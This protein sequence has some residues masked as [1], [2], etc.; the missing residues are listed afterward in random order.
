MAKRSQRTQRPGQAELTE[1]GDGV[2]ISVSSNG[3]APVRVQITRLGWDP[4]RIDADPV[5]IGGSIET[6][7]GVTQKVDDQQRWVGLLPSLAT[8]GS[9]E[10]GRIIIGL[11]KDA[12][13]AC[14]RGKECPDSSAIRQLGRLLDEHP[15]IAYRVV[16][17]QDYVGWLTKRRL[18]GP[19]DRILRRRGPGRPR[20]SYFFVVEV[21]QAVVDRD[22]CS[23]AKAAETAAREYGSQLAMGKQRIQNIYSEHRDLYLATRGT[24]SVL[25]AE[26]AS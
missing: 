16:D 1:A 6:A 4:T 23:V 9:L 13:R 7:H 19:L 24:Q 12:V 8:S 11:I 3:V 22:Q 17:V 26:F 21:V 2:G 10:R 25:G 15:E 5:T 18:N 20:E 14:R